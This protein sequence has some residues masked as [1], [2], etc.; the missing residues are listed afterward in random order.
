MIS[1]INKVQYFLKESDMV[2]ND[3]YICVA[4]KIV[5]KISLL[6]LLL[7][8]TGNMTNVTAEKIREK[9]LKYLPL[10]CTVQLLVSLSVQSCL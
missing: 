5:V 8:N 7:V 1:L 2:V 4:H 9:N 6:Q 3:Q 10:A